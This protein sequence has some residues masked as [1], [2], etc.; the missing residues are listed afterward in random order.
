MDLQD[1]SV[2]VNRCRPGKVV[3]AQHRGCTNTYL[4]STGRKGINTSAL[5]S[6]PKSVMNPGACGGLGFFWSITTAY[7]KLLIKPSGFLTLTFWVGTAAVWHCLHPQVGKKSNAT[8]R[9]VS[10]VEWTWQLF[11]ICCGEVVVN[12]IACML[13]AVAMDVCVEPIAFS[14]ACLFLRDWCC[15]AML[16]SLICWKLSFR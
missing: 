2:G 4:H 12:F 8:G 10:G 15:I 7:W 6:L 16:Q 9:K 11:L 14:S 3:I 5:A 1:T 13:E